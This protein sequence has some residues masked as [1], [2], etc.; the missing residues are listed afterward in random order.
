MKLDLLPEDCIAHVLS[1]T[2]PRDACGSSLVSSAVRDASCSNIVWEKFLPSDYQEIM[3]R[4][5]FPVTFTTKKDLF[6]KLSTPLLIDGGKKTSSIE[7]L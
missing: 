4:L 1:C 5:V 3:S 7:G 2:S 6:A